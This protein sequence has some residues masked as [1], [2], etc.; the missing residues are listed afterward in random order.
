MAKQT[1]LAG[2]ALLAAMAP[3]PPRLPNGY[4]LLQPHFEGRSARERDLALAAWRVI[5][6]AMTPHEG[7]FKL[8]KRLEQELLSHAESK[9]NRMARAMVF[10]RMARGF[11]DPL[12]AQGFKKTWK[13]ESWEEQLAEL[14]TQRKLM[15]W[16]ELKWLKKLASFVKQKSAWDVASELTNWP[17]FK[18][19][20]FYYYKPP[21]KEQTNARDNCTQ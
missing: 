16:P 1:L 2:S 21:K 3:T 20:K 7:E 5:E 15:N 18:V 10:H 8:P 4:D 19:R 14:K 11:V 17:K 12:L 9:H 13:D 6:R